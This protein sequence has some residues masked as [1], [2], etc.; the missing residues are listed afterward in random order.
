MTM[1]MKNIHIDAI[2]AMRK[3]RS[4]GLRYPPEVDGTGPL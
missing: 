2:M 3:K 1:K 4:K